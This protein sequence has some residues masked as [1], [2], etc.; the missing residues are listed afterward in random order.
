MTDEHL[1]ESAAD[2]LVQ[3]V[4][5][6]FQSDGLIAKAAGG[7]ESV[8]EKAK[9]LDL[10]NESGPPCNRNENVNKNY[11]RVDANALAIVALIFSVA[12]LVV[13]FM[14]SSSHDRL[15]AK[16]QQIVDAKIAAGNAKVS[17]S[18]QQQIADAK[19]VAHA[20]DTNSRVALDKVEQTQVQLGAAGLIKPSTH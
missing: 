1:V 8:I 20:A 11:I 14:Q 2:T 5:K 17:E 6:L 13:V 10:A 19:A 9:T 16:D 7:L 4:K 15:A 18:V 12:A 3:R